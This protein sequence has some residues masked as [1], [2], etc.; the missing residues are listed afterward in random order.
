MSKIFA[1]DLIDFAVAVLIASARPEPA[2]ALSRDF[3]EELAH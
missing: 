2:F 3:A 1:T